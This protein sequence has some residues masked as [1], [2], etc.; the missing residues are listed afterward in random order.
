[1]QR[2]NLNLI[3]I[4]TA[5]GIFTTVMTSVYIVNHR[6]LL[7]IQ[8]MYQQKI[9]RHQIEGFLESLPFYYEKLNEGELTLTLENIP[10]DQMDSVLEQIALHSKE[11]QEQSYT[12]SWENTSKSQRL[13]SIQIQY[14][15]SPE[16]EKERSLKLNISWKLPG[17]ISKKFQFS[18]LLLKKN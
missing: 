16:I 8:A 14:Q 3:E 13:D 7:E 12:I 1:M 5:M 6:N 10:A 18:T 17:S 15:L 2:K 9:V 11:I 4:V